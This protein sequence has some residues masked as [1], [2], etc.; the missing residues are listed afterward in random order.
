MIYKVR[1]NSTRL[2]EA[3]ELPCPFSFLHPADSVS[4][5]LMCPAASQPKGI[6]D[7]VAT[8]R[9]SDTPSFCQFSICTFQFS[10]FNLAFSS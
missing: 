6:H 2:S 3:A 10:T 7:P 4:F 1:Q 9:G 5:L 8:A